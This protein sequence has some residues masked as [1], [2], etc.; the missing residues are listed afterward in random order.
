[1]LGVGVGEGGERADRDGDAGEA[2]EP[3][4]A[5]G[6]GD[7]DD[8]RHD[9]VEQ[10]AATEGG[11]RT[12][13]AI[14][15]EVQIEVDQPGDEQGHRTTEPEKASDVH[16]RSLCPQI[17]AAGG[18][19]DE[20]LAST[21]RPGDRVFGP[22]ARRV[23]LSS[24]D[25][26]SAEPVEHRLVRLSCGVGVV[27]GA[28]VVEEGVVDALEHPHLVGQAGRREGGLGGAGASR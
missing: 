20:R 10:D 8:H 18:T 14:P 2:D 13:V 17:D 28:G 25:E 19:A 1:M 3:L 26:V 22:V 23:R 15:A 9:G 16:A 6:D 11:H 7:G 21:D 27:A 4:P 12:G 24:S 5:C